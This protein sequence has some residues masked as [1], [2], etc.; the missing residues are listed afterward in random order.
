MLDTSV[1]SMSGLFAQLGLPNAPHEIQQFVDTHR[2]L[3]QAEPLASAT[4]WTP[5]QADF[6]RDAIAKDS[7]WAEIVDELNVLLRD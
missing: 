7:D 1:H 2:P 3:P 6:L 5:S 4:C